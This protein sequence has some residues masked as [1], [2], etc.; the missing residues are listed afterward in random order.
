M[1]ASIVHAQLRIPAFATSPT[2]GSAVHGKVEELE[3]KIKLIDG[4]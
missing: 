1:V 3:G 2:P 4:D